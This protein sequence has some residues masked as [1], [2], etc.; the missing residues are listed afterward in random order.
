MS[1]SAIDKDLKRVRQLR[2]ATED[3]S[4]AMA[5]PGIALVFLLAALVWA[6]FAVASGPLSYLVIIA[7]VIAAYMALN[8]GANDVAN[9]MGPAVGS[10]ALTMTGALAIAAICEAA[11][12]L[13]A[14]G[15]VVSTI[16]RDII[17]PGAHIDGTAFIMVMMAAL[18]SSALW[19]NLATI[20]GAPVSTT[21]AVVGGVV[22]AGVAAAGF[23][24]IIWPTI[25]KI[26]A[27]WVISPLMGGLLAAVLLTVINFTILRQKE[28]VLSARIWV[29]VLVGVMIGI[30]AMYMSMKGLSRVW[31]PQGHIVLLIGLVAGGLGWLAAQPWVRA[32]TEGMDNTNK[33][34]GTL[35]RLPLIF[36]TALLSFA[37]GANDVA[38]AVGPLAAIV[39]A[40]Q[41]GDV[42][43]SVALP[44]W[45]L[46]IGALGLALGLA[47]F[48][49]RLIRTVGE[50]IT[51]LNEIRGYCVALSA[52]ATVLVASALGLPV[53]STHIAVG[54]VFGVGFLR[55]GFSNQGIRNKAVSPEGVF[56]RTDHLNK[57][58]EEAV[59]NYQKRQRRYLVRRQHAFSIGAAWVITVP[60]AALLAAGI[61]WGMVL[62]FGL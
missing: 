36:A 21:H 2:E 29:P 22:G 27:S 23:S 31:K 8:I 13:L 17:V 42:G 11:G 43:G 10:K 37:H 55:E 62:L 49:P 60:A 51:K 16:S 24:A 39:S 41:N 12:A 19:V 32:R 1:K 48:G 45:V 18:L 26:A 57:T 20:I 40:V 4:R 30:F 7:T 50:K 61:F 59:A 58:A 46:A 5:A 6:S 47:L 15:D 54:A 9:N 52:A 28:K 44:I 35:F 56:L 38:N 53:S 34:V 3:S 14:G 33:Q 25:A